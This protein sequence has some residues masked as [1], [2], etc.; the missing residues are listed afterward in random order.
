MNLKTIARLAG[1][2]AVTVSNVINGNHN[3]VSQE[4]IERVQ[5][6]I[7]ETHYQPNAAARSLVLKQ[8]R[9]I[10]VVIPGL[11]EEQPFSVSPYNAQILAHLERY[12]RNRGYYLMIRCV[13]RSREVIPAF[14]T[15]NVDGALLLGAFADDVEELQREL[16]IPAVFIDAYAEEMPFANVGIDDYKGGYL[17]AEYLLERGHEQIAFVGPSTEHLGVMRERY[18]GF[19]DA[20]GDR[21]MEPEFDHCFEA[22]TLYEC[23]VAAGK[24]IAFSDLCFTAAVAMSDVLALGVMEGLRQCG[25]SVPEDFSV[26]GFDDLP[27][28]RYSTP[29][30][31]TISQHLEEKARCAG[32]YLFS[33][34]EN[35]E[36]YTG[37]KKVDV[38]L[39]ERQSVRG[40]ASDESIDLEE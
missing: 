7:E 1:V 26:V 17:A 32:E 29:Q 13:R 18:R 21:G 11:T 33:M 38:E 39:I 37:Q 2:S 27:E 14:S 19:C 34:I 9:I 22:D 36:P 15:W 23:G 25:L 40:I 3:K 28:C 10:G 24:R 35:K 16:D 30:L 6:I 12:I 8:S 20:F 31:T 5:K 4:T